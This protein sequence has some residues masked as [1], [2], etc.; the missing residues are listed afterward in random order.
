MSVI[1]GNL[2]LVLKPCCLEQGFGR[3]LPEDYSTDCI[4]KGLLEHNCTRSLI[5]HLWWLKLMESLI[6]FP[7]KI[8]KTVTGQ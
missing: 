5:Y 2:I 7:E 8:L 3:V 6:F 4:C 1:L